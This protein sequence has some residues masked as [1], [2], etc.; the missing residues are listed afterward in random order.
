MSTFLL[1]IFMSPI[2]QSLISLPYEEKLRLLWDLWDSMSSEHEKR[3]LS[4]A[5]KKELQE[6]LDEY[7]RTGQKGDSWDV[8]K[9]R[10]LGSK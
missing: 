10:I 5:V 8:V 6:S 7:R 2:V 3:P 9:A 4:E 1:I